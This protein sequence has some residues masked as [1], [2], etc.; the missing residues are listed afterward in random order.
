MWATNI[1]PTKNLKLIKTDPERVKTIMNTALQIAADY[2]T[3]RTLFAVYRQKLQQML[4][5]KQAQAT[6]Y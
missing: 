5:L 4:A 2:D 6:I 3:F 1:W